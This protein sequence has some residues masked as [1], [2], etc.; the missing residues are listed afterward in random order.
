MQPPVCKPVLPQA[1]RRGHEFRGQKDLGS[2]SMPAASS[3]W[4]QPS[5]H[6]RLHTQGLKNKQKKTLTEL[7][8]KHEN[9]YK[10]VTVMIRLNAHGAYMAGG[11]LRLDLP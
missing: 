2:N 7:R 8:I 6:P 4:D 11:L 1:V 9:S 5:Y 10:L 3:L